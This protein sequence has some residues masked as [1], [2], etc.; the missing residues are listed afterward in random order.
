[1]EKR[2]T[3][4]L[5]ELETCADF[6]QFSEENRDHFLH[7]TLAEFLENRRIQRGLKKSELIRRCDM[8]EVYAYQILAGS[9]K[10]ERRKLLCFAFG[11]ELTLA[12]TQDMLKI[13][14]LPPLYAKKE[15]DCVVI[16]CLYK[17]FSVAQ[18]NEMLYQYGQPTIG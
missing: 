12:Q 17:R 15:F 11:L 4:L 18:T 2:T 5:N 14:E 9:K 16:Y 7:T 13:A 6:R 3:E 1:M 10:P 8:S